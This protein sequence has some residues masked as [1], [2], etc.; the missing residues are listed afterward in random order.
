MIIGEPTRELMSFSFWLKMSLLAFGTFVLI[1]F[2]RA[3][4][5][6]EGRW[7]EV[8]IDRWSIKM[9]TIAMLLIWAGVIIS[10]RLIAYDSI[11]GSWSHVPKD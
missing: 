3:V 11:W 8:L 10:G 2:G 7:E 9:I 5:G 6:N 4:R 1:V